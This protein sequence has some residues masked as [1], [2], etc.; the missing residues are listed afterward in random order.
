LQ[1]S[2]QPL[3]RKL[4]IDER[5]RFIFI[6]VI[7]IV[8]LASLLAM[9]PDN[10]EAEATLQKSIRVGRGIAYVYWIGIAT[11]AFFGAVKSF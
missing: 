8:S 11:V 6:P 10:Q 9:E 4:P 3:P 2:T 5:I 7:L 1:S